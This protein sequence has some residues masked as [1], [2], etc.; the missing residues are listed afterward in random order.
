MNKELLEKNGYKVSKLIRDSLF[1]K[2][3]NYKDIGTL[4]PITVDE[5][6]EFN[7][8]YSNF[9]LINHSYLN[10]PETENLL[11]TL[12]VMNAYQSQLEKEKDDVT[13]VVG[14]HLGL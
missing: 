7:E 9:I 1:N 13:E 4:Y 6:E 5:F 11:T 8:K 12:V 14:L 3:T 2:P 10:I